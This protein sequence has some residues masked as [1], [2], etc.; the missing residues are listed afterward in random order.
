MRRSLGPLDKVANL[1]VRSTEYD[2]NQLNVNFHHHDKYSTV[3]KL[4]TQNRQ[5]DEL[6]INSTFIRAKVMAKRCRQVIER[7]F[8]LN[9]GSIFDFRAR[10]KERKPFL[11]ESP[12]LIRNAKQEKKDIVFI[13]LE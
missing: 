9:S 7:G 6:P 12:L 11:S 2:A 3:Q 8:R 10:I 1:A 13:Y 4:K 5:H